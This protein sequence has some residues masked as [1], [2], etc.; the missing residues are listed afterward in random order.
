MV[1]Y[2]KEATP[3]NELVR[4]SDKQVWKAVTKKDSQLFELLPPSRPRAL[5]VRSHP[6]ILLRIKTERF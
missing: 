3:V 1:T 4:K 5:R 6:F 2:L